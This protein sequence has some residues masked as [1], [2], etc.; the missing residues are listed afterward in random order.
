MKRNSYLRPEKSQEPYNI[1]F[2]TF[3]EYFREIFSARVGETNRNLL[4]IK[5]PEIEKELTRYIE[6]TKTES[7]CFRPQ[8][9]ILHGLT[10]AGKSSVCQHIAAKYKTNDKTLS[11]YLDFIGRHHGLTLDEHFYDREPQEQRNI[12]ENKAA[13]RINT[14]LKGR[15]DILCIENNIKLD[16]EFYEHTRSLYPGYF[17]AS[18]F[19][20]LSDEEKNNNLRDFLNSPDQT[21]PVLAILRFV[22]M[23]LNITSVIIW[24]DNVD[25]QPREIVSALFRMLD[26]FITSIHRRLPELP[27]SDKIGKTQIVQNLSG[28][29]ILTC[30]SRT[31]LG[32]TQDQE[33]IEGARG[34]IPIEMKSEVTI[35]SSIL[36]RRVSMCKVEHF[37]MEYPAEHGITVTTRDIKGFLNKFLEKLSGLAVE[38]DLFNICNRNYARSFLNLKYLIQNKRFINYDVP[39]VMSSTDHEIE[40]DSNR[41]MK[42]LAYGNPASEENIVYPTQS[43]F[44]Q[45]ILD[46]DPIN[47]NTFLGVVKVLKLLDNIKL[48]FIT[49]KYLAESL[50]RIFGLDINSIKWCINKCNRERILFSESGFSSTIGEDESIEISPK[51]E[52]ML[53]NLLYGSST[54]LEIYIDD[55]DVPT[56]HTTLLENRPRVPHWNQYPERTNFLDTLNWISA[57]SDFENQILTDLDNQKAGVRN[58]TVAMFGGNLISMFFLNSLDRSRQGLYRN[59]LRRDDCEALKKEQDRIRALA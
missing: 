30:R 44:I 5:V 9:A 42:A 4:Y 21:V 24:V 47:T 27:F 17:Q 23:K 20:P 32:L 38:S 51:G 28:A 10:G 45:N 31:Y 34:H 36:K 46:W 29:A 41:I 11:C 57:F 35:L 22:S 15:L 6:A 13:E 48:N 59:A 18:T 39:V 54:L 2:H 14:L 8:V 49:F 50:E 52:T 26:D 37:P 43:T 33:G 16:L 7:T 12:A 40:L 1:F 56:G 3:E 19:L 25:E 58:A 53:R 55:I